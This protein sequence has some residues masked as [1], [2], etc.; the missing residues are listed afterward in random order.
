[1]TKKEIVSALR[2]LRATH[3]IA[4]DADIDT[5]LD[6]LIRRVEEFPDPPADPPSDLAKWRPGT[7]V[8]AYVP[9]DSL[10]SVRSAI[11]AGARIIIEPG[12]PE[13]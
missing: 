4:A 2:S 6:D 13:D 1:L 11:K 12:K 5:T 7:S 9:D 3:R 10:I 8:V